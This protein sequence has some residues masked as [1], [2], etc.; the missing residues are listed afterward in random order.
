MVDTNQSQLTSHFI[1]NPKSPKCAHS[2]VMTDVALNQSSDSS[3]TSSDVRDSRE[4][5]ALN[6][7]S[8]TSCNVHDSRKD[9]TDSHQLLTTCT[10]A[11]KQRILKEYNRKT[12]RTKKSSRVS[13]C[14]GIK[15]FPG[16]ALMSWN[17]SVYA[18]PAVNLWGITHSLSIIE[19]KVADSRN[20]Q[21]VMVTGMQ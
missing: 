14:S 10:R 19:K 7:S 3:T 17:A 4:D 11:P 21:K 1:K 12:F 6:Q 18:L 2:S 15:H 13:I 8:A 5:C 16:L 9:S 20:M